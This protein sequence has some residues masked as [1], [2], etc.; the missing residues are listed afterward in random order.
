MIL[1]DKEKFA[2]FEGVLY[3]KLFMSFD[4]QFF[5]IHQYLPSN[6]LKDIACSPQIY[7]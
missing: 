3:A 1:I 5:K 6:Y 2:F 4:L 7:E